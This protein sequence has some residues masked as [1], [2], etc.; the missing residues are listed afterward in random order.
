MWMSALG[1]DP[2]HEV[3]NLGRFRSFVVQQRREL[4]LGEP[5]YL[6][7]C[8]TRTGYVQV[9]PMLTDGTMKVMTMHRIV[10]ETF[11]GLR[12][13]GFHCRHLNGVKTDNR[14]VNLRWGTAKEN[15]ED[16]V[17]HGTSPKGINH[18]G[19]KLNEEQVIQIRAIHAGGATCQSIADQYG[20][21]NAT[22]SNI[23]KRRSW[24]HV[25]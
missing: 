6:D 9:S 22:I 19:A 5:K 7:G 17:R 24:G 1:L 13:E 12:P 18:P 11:V 23:V 4:R 20:L 21:C 25:G 10:L 15:G 2:R 3:S 14:L 16:R 8:I